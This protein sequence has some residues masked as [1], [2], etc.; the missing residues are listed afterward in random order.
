MH[1]PDNVDARQCKI[2]TV[3]SFICEKSSYLFNHGTALSGANISPPTTSASAGP[4]AELYVTIAQKAKNA[5]IFVAGYPD[6]VPNKFWWEC[7]EGVLDKDERESL[8]AQVRPLNE[9]IQ[10]AISIA[11]G[12]IGPRIVFVDVEGAFKGHE[13]CSKNEYV[14]A[15]NVTDIGASYHPNAAGQLAYATQVW[16]AMN[17]TLALP[18]P[19]VDAQAIP[20]FS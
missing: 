18:L 14:T 20:E 13:P 9:Q 6:I 16:S 5:T 11:T 3:S 8:R 19:S 17:N 12:R 1:Y 2:C 10:K 15:I 4:L 7:L